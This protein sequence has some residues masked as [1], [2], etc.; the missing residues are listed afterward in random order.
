M[1]E[2]R[3][4]IDQ[5]Q[6][7]LP[8]GMRERIKAVGDRNGRSMNA[9]IVRALEMAF[10]EP[11]SISARLEELHHLFSAM[12][13]IR[14]YGGAIDVITEEI[15]NAIE[16]GAAGRDPTLDDDAVGELQKA[17]LKWNGRQD[18]DLAARKR[19]V[20]EKYQSNGEAE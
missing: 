14:G 20:D 15:V 13:K 8:P 17:L 3:T 12:R 10:P 2:N 1:A 6:L 7:R 11:V 5:F 18:A 9:E 4:N 19:A 16:A